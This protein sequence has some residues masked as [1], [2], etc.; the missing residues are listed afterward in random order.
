MRLLPQFPLPSPSPGLMYPAWVVIWSQASSK[1]AQSASAPSAAPRISQCAAEGYTPVQAC[2]SDDAGAV[3]PA[4]ILGALLIGLTASRWLE[5]WPIASAS[6]CLTLVQLRGHVHDV[7]AESS[8]ELLASLPSF[9]Q[10]RS[11]ASEPCLLVILRAVARILSGRY[12]GPCTHTQSRGGALC[13]ARVD[14]RL[15]AHTPYVDT[16]VLKGACALRYYQRLVL[17]GQGGTL[18]VRLVGYR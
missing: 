5:I 2:A 11:Y 10:R 15:R 4:S 17:L 16:L 7:S 14:E 9:T 1:A 8:Q 18:M 3:V 6:S 13:V 12:T